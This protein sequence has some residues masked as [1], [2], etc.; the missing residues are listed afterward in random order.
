MEFVIL[1]VV[2]AL[3]AVGVISGLVVSSRKKKQLPPRRRRARRPSHLPPS[4]RVG[5]EAEEPREE[6]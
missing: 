1:A 3:V 2:I 5:E 4:P 6:S